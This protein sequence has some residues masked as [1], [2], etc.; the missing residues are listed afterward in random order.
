VL[1]KVVTRLA[2]DR[3]G[4]THACRLC[5]RDVCMSGPGCPMEHTMT[6]DAPRPQPRR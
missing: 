2:D 4:A 1:A 3:P 5:D 6:P